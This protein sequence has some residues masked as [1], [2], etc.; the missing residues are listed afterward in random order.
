MP[1]PDELPQQVTLARY[2]AVYDQ[3][4][5]LKV[6]E[7]PSTAAILIFDGTD[8]KWSTGGGASQIPLD[9][10]QTIGPGGSVAG[11]LTIDDNHKM[12]ILSPGD[13]DGQLRVFSIKDRI[14]Q[15]LLVPDVFGPGKGLLHKK[16]GGQIEWLGNGPDDTPP[17]TGGFYWGDVDGNV[18]QLALG[19]VG[20]VITV[21]SDGI[22]GFYKPSGLTQITG[23]R[24]SGLDDVFAQSVSATTIRV[25]S[26]SLTVK[27]ISGDQI[28]ATGVDLTLDITATGPLGNDVAGGASA[29]HFYFLYVIAKDDGTLSLVASLSDVGPDLTASVD[30]VYW[31]LASI[32]YVEGSGFVRQY[33][34]RGKRFWIVDTEF[35]ANWTTPGAY[36]LVPGTVALGTIV[37]TGFVKT[38]SGRIGGGTAETAPRKYILSGTNTG[39]GCQTINNDDSSGGVENLKYNNGNFFDIPIT[40]PSTPNFYVKVKTAAGSVRTRIFIDG[41]TI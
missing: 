31:G 37:P 40:D 17:G 1:L 3:Y 10:V 24:D 4:G 25:V 7:L 22:P 36:T 21:G 41:F 12:S 6:I 19:S 29:G 26:P 8:L 11:F 27:N 28:L 2:L 16:V 33:V 35:V 18:Q 39:V 38:V 13:Q 9:G 14:P 34:Q 23:S 15:L 32:Y 20:T 5:S 30:Y